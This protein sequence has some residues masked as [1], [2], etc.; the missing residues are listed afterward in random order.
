MIKIKIQLIHPPVDKFYT[1]Y[2]YEWLKSAPIGLELIASK[3]EPKMQGC[4]VQIFDGNNLSLNEIVEKVYGDYVGVSDWYSCHHN[5]LE[6]LKQAKRKGAVT[7][8]GGPNATHIAERILNNHD[9]VDYVVVRGG[10]D[11]FSMLVRG[12]DSS[13]IPNLVYRRG[14]AIAENKRQSVE[15]DTVFDLE[16]LDHSFYD[17]KNPFPLSSIRG[18]IKAELDKRCSFCSMDYKLKLMSPINVWRQIDLLHSR[19]GFEYFFETGDSFIVGKYPEK[20]LE[21]RPDYLKNIRFRIYASPEQINPDS[22]KTLKALNV[23]S[24]FLGL[25]TANEHILQRAGKKYSKTSVENALKF[26]NNANIQVQIPLIYG[27]PGETPETL[28]ETYQFVKE[29]LQKYPRMAILVSPAMPLAGTELFSSLLANKDVRGRYK[30]DLTGDNFD[31]EQLI[32]LQTE[33]FTSVTFEDIMDYMA[34]TK[35]LVHE[36]TP[37]FGFARG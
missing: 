19:Y 35:S 28:E 18:C 32:R 27:L 25:E 6:I 20:L 16:H 31:Y 22:V 11:A 7:V 24:M 30:G 10:E 29:T 33:Y 21:T 23:A 1:G 17:R 8:I 3:V 2:I 37:G 9:F 34:K 26:L 5:A 12:E 13:K 14:N 36:K 4:S 15:L